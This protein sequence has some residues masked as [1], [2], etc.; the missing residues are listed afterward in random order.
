MPTTEPPPTPTLDVTTAPTV[1]PTLTPTA[2]A[3]LDWG[4]VPESLTAAVALLALVGAGL[5]V[6][7][8]H[9]AVLASR[10]ANKITQDAHLADTSSAERRR[11][12]SSTARH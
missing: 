8:A 11:L 4:S 9:R 12:D 10:E 3:E 2:I 1:A 7:F 6:Y 5:S